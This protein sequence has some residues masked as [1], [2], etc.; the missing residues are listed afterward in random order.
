MI[1]KPKTVDRS[2]ILVQLHAL[3]RKDIPLFHSIICFRKKP[4]VLDD[5]LKK[6]GDILLAGLNAI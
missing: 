2:N 6:R 4:W 3:N 5:I 1:S